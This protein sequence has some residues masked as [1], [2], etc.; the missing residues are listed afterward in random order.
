MDLCRFISVYIFDRLRV[1]TEIREIVGVRVEILLL[2]V[3]AFSTNSSLPI[4]AKLWQVY[5]LVIWLAR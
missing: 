2:L 3:E 1:K 4:G 5:D